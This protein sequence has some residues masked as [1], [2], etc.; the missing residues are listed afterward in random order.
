MTGKISCPAC[1]EERRLVD[2]GT[3]PEVLGEISG[4]SIK[5][6]RFNGG[7]R[8]ST[9]VSGPWLKVSC[10]NPEH[11]TPVFY[12]GTKPTPTNRLNCTA[13]YIGHMYSSGIEDFLR[14]VLTLG[15]YSADE[16]VEILLKLKK[17]VLE[18]GKK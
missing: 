6:M 9:L 17:E 3:H 10:G 12:A 4:E 13:L 8:G 7:D 1:T 2:I 18:V 15:V 11:N 14:D 5:I 16:L